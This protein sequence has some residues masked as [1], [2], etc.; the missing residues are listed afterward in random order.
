MPEA[1]TNPRQL[2]AGEHVDYACAADTR[3]HHDE[4][5]VV[6]DNFADHCRFFA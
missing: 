1:L 4:A 6:V 5:R 2:F 3:F